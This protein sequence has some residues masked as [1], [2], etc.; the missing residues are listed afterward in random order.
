[1][2]I[3]DQRITKQLDHIIYFQ[4][5]P[6]TITS[7][8]H[9][10]HNFNHLTSIKL[11]L[12]KSIFFILFQIRLSLIKLI[13]MNLS[14]LPVILL[15]F[16]ELLSILIYHQSNKITSNNLLLKYME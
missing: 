6:T 5:I 16:M 3:F 10:N 2:S 15:P 12:Y 9:H 11:K 13:N 14:T 8:H 4:I 1:M 7:N